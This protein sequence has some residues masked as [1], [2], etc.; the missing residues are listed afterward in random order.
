MQ[1]LFG[2]VSHV[3]RDLSLKEKSL[4]VNQ[5]LYELVQDCLAVGRCRCVIVVDDIN[6]DNSVG[7]I[8]SRFG[9]SCHDS[10]QAGSADVEAAA[11]LWPVDSHD[12]GQ[13]YWDSAA[14]SLPRKSCQ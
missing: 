7:T 2:H 12:K 13:A 6:D 3:L 1:L 4:H 10:A 14:F 8:A 11:A 5:L 9:M